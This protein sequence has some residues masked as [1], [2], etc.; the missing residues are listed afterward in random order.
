MIAALSI[1]FVSSIVFFITCVIFLRRKKKYH[2]AKLPTDVSETSARAYSDCQNVC[3]DE[4]LKTDLNNKE[5][6]SLK[7]IN[8]NITGNKTSFAKIYPQTTNIK[9]TVLQTE[10]T[11]LNI[12]LAQTFHFS[13]CNKESI[14]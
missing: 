13:E 8:Q 6:G 2:H 11:S 7:S 12:D 1:T 4:P 10:E 9:N 3:D 14:L 5:C